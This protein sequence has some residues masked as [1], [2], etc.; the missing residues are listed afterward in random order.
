MGLDDIKNKVKDAVSGD[1]GEKI[2]DAGIDKAGDAVDAKTG[3][4]GTVHVDKAQQVAD[5]KIGQ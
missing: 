5:G 4:K 3:G 1:Q 2:T